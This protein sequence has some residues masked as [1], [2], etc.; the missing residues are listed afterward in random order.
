ME[1]LKPAINKDQ[2]SLQLCVDDSLR[3]YPLLA[4][5]PTPGPKQPSLELKPLPKNLR[6]KYLDDDPNR[7]VKV[8]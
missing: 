5:N 6:Y 3:E 4:P 8:N 1:I 2:A 7:P